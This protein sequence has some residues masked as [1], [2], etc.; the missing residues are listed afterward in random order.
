M[1][2]VLPATGRALIVTA[3]SRICAIPLQYVVETMRPL[4]IAELSGTPPFV[5]GLA[6]IRG[7]LLPV[8]DLA[9]L[10][11]TE[12]GR[13]E[14]GRFVTVAVGERRMALAVS[15]V[16]G[17]VDVDPALLRELP[18]LLHNAEASLI[19]AIG[20]RDAQLLMMLRA[21]HIVPDAVWARV[22]EG[23]ATA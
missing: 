16:T 21:T 4:A 3:G 9:L 17:L 15:T 14:I 22:A 6:V 8:V 11:G 13:T 2:S 18:S 20:T 12:L 1:S 19:E 5:L 7:D 23:P 10:L